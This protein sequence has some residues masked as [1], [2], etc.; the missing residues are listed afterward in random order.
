MNNQKSIKK[1]QI[2]SMGK[3]AKSTLGFPEL[4]GN[5]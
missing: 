3:V 5:W 1:N 2:L 4:I